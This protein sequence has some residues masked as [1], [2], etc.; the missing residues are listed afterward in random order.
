[1]L[2]LESDELLESELE[3]LESDELLLQSLEVQLLL[4]S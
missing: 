3:L 2:L 4:V 1:L